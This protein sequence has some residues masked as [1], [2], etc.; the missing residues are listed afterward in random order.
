MKV[1]VTGCRG[2]L[3]QDVCKRLAALDVEYDGVDIDDFDLTDA[4]ETER[5]VVRSRPD[6]IIHCAAYTAVDK[7][8]EASD[9]CF[10]V[11]E[12]GTF[13][14]AKAAADLGTKIVYLSTDYVFDGVGS[15]PHKEEDPTN[16]LNVYGASKLAGERAIL[17][18]TERCFIVRTSWVFGIH[19]R[20]F[21]ETMLRL[22]EQ[23]DSVSV[24][25]DQIGSP[26]YTVDLARLLCSMIFTEKYGIYHAANEGFCSWYDLAC[27]TMEL[28]GRPCRVLP[29]N[30]AEYP[31]K[32]KRPLNSR[33]SKD[34]LTENG[35]ERLPP[36]QDA[37]ERFLKER[38]DF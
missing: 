28:A 10:S 7:A 33:L 24:V 3:G 4:A 5:C 29:I 13:N 36:W 22:G 20:N 2:Q 32:A 34:K 19:G 1:L 25:C 15:L 14:L 35:F 9:L 31:T 16:P 12:K 37:L 11:N 21:V 27:R 6:A 23:R 30:S 18:Q 38:K 8:E 26:T 17:S